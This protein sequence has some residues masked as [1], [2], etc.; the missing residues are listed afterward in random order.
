MHTPAPQILGVPPPPQTWPCGQLSS[1]T[2]GAPVSS[3]AQPTGAT[4]ATASANANAAKAD[5]VVFDRNAQTLAVTNLTTETAGVRAQWT[6]SGKTL[7]D[8]P[9]VEGSVSIANAPIATLL[10]QLAVTPPKGVPSA[11][12]TGPGVWR[13]AK[14]P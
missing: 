4:L 13:S 7:V 8:D 11:S 10:E 6:L 9:S 12:V 3:G 5:S 2:Q 1:V 14:G